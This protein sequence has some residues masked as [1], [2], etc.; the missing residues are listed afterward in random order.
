MKADF[1]NGGACARSAFGDAHALVAGAGTDNS[2]QSGP[3][4]DRKGTDYGMVMSAKLVISFEA[5]LAQ[6]ATLSIAANIQDAT[7]DDGTG[8][9]DFGSVLASAVVATGDTGGSTEQ[10]TIELDFDLAAANRYVRSQITSDLSAANTDT[11]T[12]V[13]TWVFFGADRKPIS[14]TLVSDNR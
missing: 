13:A 11:A 5:V 10:G 9:D 8:A 1:H 3:W 14:K 4:V 2:E 6:D 12:V 7:A